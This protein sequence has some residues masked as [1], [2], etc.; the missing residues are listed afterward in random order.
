M[1]L[2]HGDIDSENIRPG[3]QVTISSPHHVVRVITADQLSIEAASG[4]R[5]GGVV[6]DR[7]GPEM[8]LAL[9][10]GHTVSLTMLSDDSIARPND[11]SLPFSRQVWRAD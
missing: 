2:W 5:I 3:V 9:D 4:K 10:D 6:Q 8:R 7:T 11:A 1:S